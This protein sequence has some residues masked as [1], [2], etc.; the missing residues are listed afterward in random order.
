[1]TTNTF[2]VVYD[3]R[4]MLQ[5]LT[6]SCDGRPFGRN[7]H[8]PKTDGR[9]VPLFGG[10]DWHN[11][12]WVE[13]YLRTKWHLYPSSRLA[14]TNMSQNLG[15]VSLLGAVALFRW[16]RELSPHQHN[17]AWAEA[18]LRTKWHLDPSSC[19]ATIDIVRK[20]GSV[21]FFG[22]L[23]PHVTQ[24]AQGRCLPACQVSR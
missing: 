18:Y 6:S 24:C 4:E 12:A 22:E 13:A 2:R 17:V 16:G 23:R 8:R 10:G 9:A 19:L 5:V 7:R 1:V 15:A 3:S 20:L 21:P 11:V 14:T